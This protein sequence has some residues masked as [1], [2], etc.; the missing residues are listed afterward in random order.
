MT[1][2]IETHTK[3][4]VDVVAL[5]GGHDLATTESARAHLEAAIKRGSHLVV[6]LSRTD[7]IDRGVVETV[8]S[9]HERLAA[10]GHRLALVVAPGPIA[11][12]VH[13]AGFDGTV[14]MYV[15]EATAIAA[16]SVGGSSGM[17]DHH[18]RRHR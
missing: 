13:E 14:P 2:T 18:E 16:L 8:R 15:N 9:A 6:N 1:S 17:S 7:S 11:R 4:G 10:E 3:Q 5:V 12:A